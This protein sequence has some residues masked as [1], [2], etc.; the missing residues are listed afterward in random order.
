MKA[1]E[2]AKKQRE[3]LNKKKG[4]AAPIEGKDSEVGKDSQIYKD[5]IS[6]NSMNGIVN[7]ENNPN[8]KSM[9]SINSLSKISMDKGAADRNKSNNV[10]IELSEENT[11]QTQSLLSKK[12]LPPRPKK[13]KV[14]QKEEKLS[15]NPV[16][17]TYQRI[18]QQELEKLGLGHK[19]ELAKESSGFKSLHNHSMLQRF[20]SGKNFRAVDKYRSQLEMDHETKEKVKAM[21]DSWYRENVQTNEEREME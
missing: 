2:Y 15:E 13:E 19:S 4:K 9:A 16:I 5:I 7:I 17:K 18:D 12:P 1:K 14:V 8:S 3:M 10:I 20:R 6:A 21:E 11:S